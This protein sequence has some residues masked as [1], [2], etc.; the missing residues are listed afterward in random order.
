MTI[1]TSRH[2][3]STYKI[4]AQT[5]GDVNTTVPQVGV[6]KV[7]VNSLLMNIHEMTIMVYQ[8]V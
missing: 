6:I 3:C 4:F 5:V 8:S 1:F 7:T 2:S